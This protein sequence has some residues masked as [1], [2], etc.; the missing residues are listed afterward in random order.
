MSNKEIGLTGFFNGTSTRVAAC[1]QLTQALGSLQPT[2]AT[3]REI[4]IEAPLAAVQG[5]AF[6]L[7]DNRPYRIGHFSATL[8]IRSSAH[9]HLSAFASV[10]S[11]SLGGLQRTQSK[12][13]P[14]LH[15]LFWRRLLHRLSNGFW[16][17]LFPSCMSK[18]TPPYMP[19]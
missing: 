17:N 1:H 5:I 2:E 18:Q 8:S 4:Y 6:M 9:R 10:L 3:N 11:T 19:A 13:R 16:R 12:P 15:A 7:A 14:T